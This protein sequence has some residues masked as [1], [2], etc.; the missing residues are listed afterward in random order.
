LGFGNWD[1]E[2]RIWNL[3]FGICGECCSNPNAPIS[4][5]PFP[6]SLATTATAGVNHP[7]QPENFAESVIQIQ[8]FQIPNS[9]FQIPF[10]KSS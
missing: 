1:L 5:F 9:N 8:P 2:F 3:E 7:S 6:N 4:K 10:S